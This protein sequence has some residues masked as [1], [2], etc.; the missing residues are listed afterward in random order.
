MP[1][2]RAAAETWSALRDWVVSEQDGVP[3]VNPGTPDSWPE[4]QANTLRC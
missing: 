4:F 2:S 1:H 3:L